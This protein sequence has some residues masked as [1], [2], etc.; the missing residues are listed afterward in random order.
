MIFPRH[1]RD[2]EGE[3]VQVMGECWIDRLSILIH[4]H[5]RFRDFAA[6]Y[7]SPARLNFQCQ[8]RHVGPASGRF[9]VVVSRNIYLT[10]LNF[11]LRH[12]CWL[13]R[14]SKSSP[15]FTYIFMGIRFLLV[16]VFEIKLSASLRAYILCNLSPSRISLRS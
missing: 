10:A 5:F 8:C 6:A 3:K 7:L 1:A 16:L 15:L 13:W 9:I 12:L 14:F 11:L 2:N 4:A